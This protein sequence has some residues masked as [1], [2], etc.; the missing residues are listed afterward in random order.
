MYITWKITVSQKI[1]EMITQA[2]YHVTYE[3]GKHILTLEV[4]TAT[5]TSQTVPVTIS[6]KT[7]RG[8]SVVTFNKR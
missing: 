4:S 2:K 1:N 6:T 5:L 3:G 8:G 7:V